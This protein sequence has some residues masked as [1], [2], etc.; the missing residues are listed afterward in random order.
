MAAQKDD[1]KPHPAKAGLRLAATAENAGERLDKWLSTMAPALT[2][3][4]LKALIETGALRKDGAVLADAS[5]R[6]RGEEIFTLDVPPAEPAG[7]AAESIPLSIAYEDADLIV[8]D[9]PAGLVVHPAAGN[10][11]GTL[12]NALL[13][14]CGDSLSGIGGIAR[15][16]VVHRLDKDTSGLMVVAKN[17]AAHRGL[18]ALFAAHDIERVYLALVSGAPRPYAGT[19]DAPIGRGKDRRKMAV[20]DEGEESGRA[21]RAV[22]R[23]KVV[24][25]FGRT[26]ARLPGDAVASLIECRLETGRTHQIRAHLAHIGHPLLGDPVYGRP[27]LAGLKPGDKAADAALAVLASFRRQA[28]H[29]AVLGFRH[30]SS[31][32]ALRFQTPPPKDFS[33]L[34]RVLSNL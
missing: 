11:S 3:T 27:G 32:E 28:L 29:A 21:R 8:I 33:E 30:P 12:V 2:R 20:L 17:D 34:R 31:G 25:T 13:A 18:S 1:H 10:R 16:G 15:P 22:T 5:Y 6:L 9:K 26:R 7:P 23:Y 19:I 14:H 24:E 4:R